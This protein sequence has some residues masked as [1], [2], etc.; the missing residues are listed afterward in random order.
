MTRFD[1]TALADRFQFHL[2]DGQAAYAFPE[3][4]PEAALHD[5][6]LVA[7][8]ALGVLTAKNWFVPVA[9]EIA[10]REPEIDPDAW[11]HIALAA[12][13]LPSGELLLGG[14]P[15]PVRDQPPLPLAAG[16]WRVLVLCGNLDRC[17]P[18]AEGDDYYRI[19]L[20]P[21]DGPVEVRKRWAPSDPA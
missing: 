18:D 7:P 9:I 4:W 19:V 8:G 3:V 1:R 13:A 5:R 17:A 21:G 2:R 16:A 10:E 15:L 11:D 14:G 12:L 6:L 20:W